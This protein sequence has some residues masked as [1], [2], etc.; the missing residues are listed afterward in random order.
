MA[1]Q[2]YIE[3]AP[4][5]PKGVKA[6]RKDKKGPRNQEGVNTGMQQQQQQQSSR[7][8][9]VNEQYEEQ[10]Q[11]RE[12]ARGRPGSSGDT[13]KSDDALSQGVAAEEDEEGTSGRNEG[14]NGRTPKGLIHRSQ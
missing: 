9:E 1:R 10:E 8:P 4:V 11:R 2:G 12:A 6:L 5:S 14:E 13:W 3:E 7:Q